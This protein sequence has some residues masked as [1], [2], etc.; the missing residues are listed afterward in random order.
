MHLTPR[1]DA[2]AASNRT[3]RPLAFEHESLVMREHCARGRVRAFTLI[4]LLVVIGIISVLIGLLLPAV[5]AARE[6]AKTTACASNLRQLVIAAHIYAVNNQ[7]RYPVARWGTDSWDFSIIGGR[8]VP[9]LLWRG[10]ADMRIQQCPSFVGRANSLFEPFTGYNYNTSYIGHGQGET[11]EA[12]AKLVHV[13]QPSR[14]VIFGDGEYYNGAN[15][16]M[17]APFPHGGDLSVTT[18][19]AGT[20][21]FRHKGRTNVAFCDGHVKTLG[22][23]FTRTV[24][25]EVPK[26]GARTGFLSGD[27][28]LYDLE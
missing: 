3:A 19:A 13:R 15:K 4:E 1:E 26:I 23:R 14:T 6:Q 11:V 2:P 25:S 24:D 18:R 28:S 21:G 16:Y 5:H 17:R 12:P 20:Q 8:A 22:D 10:Q 7:G 9:G 27:N